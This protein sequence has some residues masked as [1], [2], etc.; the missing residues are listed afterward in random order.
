MIDITVSKVDSI[1]QGTPKAGDGPRV[2]KSPCRLVTVSGEV[3]AVASP[4]KARSALRSLRQAALS[5]KA[6]TT[7]RTNGLQTTTRPFGFS[8]RNVIRSDWCRS[9]DVHRKSPSAALE[10][11]RWAPALD[12][13]YKRYAGEQRKLHIQDTQGRFEPDYFLGSTPWTSG[14]LNRNASLSYHFDTGNTV[15]GWSGMI[16]LR[17]FCKGGDLVFPEFGVRLALR[18]GDAFL[19]NGQNHLHGVTPITNTKSSGY[20]M[21]LVYYTAEQIWKCLP[22]K[23]ELNRIKSKSTERARARQHKSVY[24]GSKPELTKVSKG[25]TDG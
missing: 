24:S 15:N 14:N 12:V 3:L 18:D 5:T 13:L 2:L 19:F 21:S 9:F 20:R 25:L 22:P 10:L 17:E 6:R 4:L 1:A 8:P 16:V 7:F 23:Q 11:V